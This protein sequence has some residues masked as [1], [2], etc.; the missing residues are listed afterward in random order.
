M[1]GILDTISKYKWFLFAWLLLNIIQASVTNLHFDEAYYWLYSNILSWGYF[2]HPP[3]IALMSKMGD[4]ISHSTLGLRIAPILMGMMVFIGILNLADNEDKDIHLFLYV[5]SFPLITS[6]IAG[7]L[8]LPDASLC[9]F[10]ILYLF[11]YKQYLKDD[12]VKNAFILSLTIAGLIYS[13]YH[14][15]LIIALTLLANTNLLLKKRFWFVTLCSILL[16]LPHFYW[17]FENGFP[18]FLYHL[19][20][21]TSG[22]S[23]NNF[24]EYI[25]GQIVLAGPFSGLL[26]I[27]LAIIFKPNNTFDKTLKYIAIGF[28]I[29]FLFYCFRSRIEAHWTSVSTIALIIISYK[30]LTH[31]KKIKRVLPYLIYPSIVLIMLARIVLAGDLFEDKLPP[32]SNF[33]NTEAWANELD[34]VAG[35][36]PVLFTNKYQ[37]L[38]IYSYAKDSWMPGAPNVNSRFSQVD[39][40]RID[41]LYDGQK[42]F[43]LSF[44]NQ[45]EWESKN[46][47][48]HRGSFIDNY[49]SYTGVIVED[50]TLIQT[51]TT[52]ALAFNLINNTSK[53]RLFDK[54]SQQRLKLD[55]SVNGLKKHVFFSDISEHNHILP[56]EKLSFTVP[57]DELNSNKITIDI[58]LS[59]NNLRVFNDKVFISQKETN[60]R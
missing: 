50:V 46:K 19:D 9:F 54:D 14:A 40:H 7:F 38:S 17:Q 20:S 23:F 47:L 41:S 36:V 59:S 1:N 28:Y 12:S 22:F 26:I 6:H 32:K 35:G 30:Q 8:N 24:F 51:D 60:G 37:N 52:V 21:R 42:V 11:S 18:S 29:F 34:S 5:I 13:K 57:L 43:A 56:F 10:F 58:A 44:G 15:L 53:K 33:R 3:M 4:F 49:Y 48:K 25:A 31:S 16:L 2:D 27:Y 55:Y 39:L 45:V